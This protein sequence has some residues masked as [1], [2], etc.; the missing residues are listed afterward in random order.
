MVLEEASGP[1]AAV[2]STRFSAHELHAGAPMLSA[3][4]ITHSR[5]GAEPTESGCE[6][7]T[8]PTWLCRLW[9]V[10]LTLLAQGTR[11]TVTDSGG[12]EHPQA[13]IG[14]AL[15][16]GWVQRLVRRTAQGPV[17]L[18]RKGF[19][20]E[21]AC[22]PGRGGRRL[23]I[24]R[25]RCLLLQGMGDAGSKLGGAQRSRLKL[26]TQLQEPRSKPIG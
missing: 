7:E 24:A 15:L 26:M 8:D 25:R 10:P 17:R 13:A 12:V 5:S 19:S 9:A 14:E 2:T 23:A 11:A 6:P 22:L 1:A 3:T 4:P 20:R 16:F 21:A 18:E